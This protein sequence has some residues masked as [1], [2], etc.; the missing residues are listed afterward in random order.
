MTAGALTLEMLETLVAELKVNAPPACCLWT[1]CELEAKILL[2]SLGFKESLDMLSGGNLLGSFA[3][4]PVRS[5]KHIK[6]GEAVFIVHSDPLK[7]YT[8]KVPD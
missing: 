3:G 8:M 6:Q 2:E 4:I 5:S 1:H 7:V